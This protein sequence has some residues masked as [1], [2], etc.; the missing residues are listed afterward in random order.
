MSEVY[1]TAVEA[2]N[3]KI[4]KIWKHKFKHAQENQKIKRIQPLLPLLH[5]EQ[6]YSPIWFLGM[7]PSVYKEKDTRL[8]NCWDITRSKMNRIHKNQREAHQGQQYFIKLKEFFQ[9]DKFLGRKDQCPVFHDIYPVRHTSQ[10]EFTK[11]LESARDLREEFN[12][13]TKILLENGGAKVIVIFNSKASEF[14]K[15]I[16]EINDKPLDTFSIFDDITFIYSSMYTGQRALDNY[17]KIRLAR[18]IKKV[19]KNKGL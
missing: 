9:N 4:I 7:N 17:A 1:K 19:I 12:H 6:A 11:F 8:M 2:Y 3:T 16:F 13:A 18:E 14:L 5:F 10:I 15:K